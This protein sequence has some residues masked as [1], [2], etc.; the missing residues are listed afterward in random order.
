[1]EPSETQDLPQ[2]TGS[3]TQEKNNEQLRGSGGGWG[4]HLGLILTLSSGNHEILNINQA[5]AS[6]KTVS[7][8]LVVS[9]PL[10]FLGPP[11]AYLSV[12]HS[13]F[14]GF[15]DLFIPSFLQSTCY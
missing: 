14:L 4:S 6:H 12:K 7:Y 9:W 10:L 1:M 11:D 13:T 5:L 2:E 3:E 8:S 15:M